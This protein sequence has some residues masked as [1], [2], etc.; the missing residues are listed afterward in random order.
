MDGNNSTTS[1][2][3]GNNSKKW[4]LIA[5]AAIIIIAIAA[6]GGLFFMQNKEENSPEEATEGANTNQTPSPEA[7]VSIAPSESATASGAQTTSNYKN[8]TYTATGTYMTHAGSE[9]I[10]VTVTL[11]DG[12]VTAVTVKE[13]AVRPMSKVMQDDFAANYKTMVMGK[14]ID[15]IKLGKVSG[16]S[17]TPMGF[18]AA[19]EDIKT[20]AKS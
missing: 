19:L 11:K 2:S 9:K 18:N 13:M 12:E 3:N 17:L 1:S 4:I 20:Q 5:A 10:G 14:N 6:G 8:G 15:V 16:S 7:M